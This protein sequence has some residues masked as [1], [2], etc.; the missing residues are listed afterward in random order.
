LANIGKVDVI[1][2]G[3]NKLRVSNDDPKFLSGEYT[4]MNKGRKCPD[5]VKKHLS[6]VGKGRKKSEETKQR[7]SEFHRNHILVVDSDGNRLNVKRDDPRYLD[8]TLISFWKINGKNKVISEDQKEKQREF[9]KLNV[10]VRDKNGDCFY[11]S[12][13]DPRYLSG[14]LTSMFAQL[15]KSRAKSDKS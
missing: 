4:H 2:S 5:E 6:E 12:R 1:D 14:E 8:G 13:D 9:N 11:I 15:N 3:G 7:M 10:M